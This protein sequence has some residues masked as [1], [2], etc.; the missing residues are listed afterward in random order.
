MLEE[1]KV[2]KDKYYKVGYSPYLKQYVLA[3]TI[4]WI[5]WYERYYSISEGEYKWF[6]NDIDKLNHLANELYHLGISSS[7]FIFSEMSAEND[8]S[9]MK[10]FNKVFQK[11]IGK[12]SQRKEDLNS[13][14]IQICHL[15]MDNVIS[16]NPNLLYLK[17]K[18]GEFIR[19]YNND[20]N[21]DIL[22]TPVIPQFRSIILC[23]L[24]LY[25]DVRFWYLSID[26]GFFW[27]SW[28]C[29]GI[30]SPTQ[31]QWGI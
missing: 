28:F 4:T 29:M 20:K 13:E 12:N 22:E 15:N 21:I 26:L 9:Q 1:I 25:I 14:I 16:V 17:D 10:L 27:G 31:T 19:L 11:D 7:R 8:S 18:D 2:N 24:L 30:K 6:D 23:D 3:I 5:A